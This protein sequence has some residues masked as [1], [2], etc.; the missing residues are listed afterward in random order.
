MLF[1]FLSQCLTVKNKLTVKRILR[2]FVLFVATGRVI[3]LP[4]FQI[5]FV[6]VTAIVGTKKWC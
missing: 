1:D 6:V 2:Y 3:L 4:A 5:D